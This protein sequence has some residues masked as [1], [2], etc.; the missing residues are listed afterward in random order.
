VIT[1]R[2]AIAGAV[3]AA[4]LVAGFAAGWLW[5]GARWDAKY[6]A[7][8]TQHA[9]AARIAE[10]NARS[11]EQQYQAGIE[12]ARTDGQERIKAVQADAIAATATAD[13]LR[14][15][16]KART[17]RATQDTGTTCRGEAA[18]ATLILYSELLDGADRRAGELAEEADRRRAAGITCERA[19]NAIQRGEVN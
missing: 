1:P 17:S 12:E 4:C 9:D 8:T 2:L 6:S 13:S 5:N 14:E 19:F 18:T 3:L 10:A 11:I 15:Q 7:L 16:L